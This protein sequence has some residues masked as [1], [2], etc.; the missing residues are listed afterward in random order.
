M[1]WWSSFA[2][3]AA[4]LCVGQS[5]NRTYGYSKENKRFWLTCFKDLYASILSTRMSY[6]TWKSL[7]L[8]DN[9]V[10]ACIASISMWFHRAKNGKL[11]STR[12]KRA[13]LLQRCRM[14][15]R[16]ATKELAAAVAKNGCFALQGKPFDSDKQR[17]RSGAENFRITICAAKWLQS[18]FEF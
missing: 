17:C 18:G 13:A 10:I 6:S 11:E 9:W 14:T 2:L 7:F 1:R 8:E 4:V 3:T 12:T 5:S 15:S 16:S